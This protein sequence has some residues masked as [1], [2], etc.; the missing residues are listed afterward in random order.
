MKKIVQPNSLEKI[1][2]RT[3]GFISIWSLSFLAGG[4]LRMRGL[5]KTSFCSQSSYSR[6]V[7]N[8]GDDDGIVQMVSSTETNTNSR[9]LANSIPHPPDLRGIVS[10]R[11]YRRTGLTRLLDPTSLRRNVSFSPVIDREQYSGPPGQLCAS[12]CS[13]TEW[14]SLASYYIG[15]TDTDHA[16]ASCPDMSLLLHPVP[17]LSWFSLWFSFS[18]LMSLSSLHRVL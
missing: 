18:Q 6:N 17:S 15:L 14:R 12:S 10:L 4:W 16:L 7:C 5:S 11:F 3:Q 8:Y 9:V 1:L 2:P 13:N